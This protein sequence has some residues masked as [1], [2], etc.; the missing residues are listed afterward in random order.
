MTKKISY[1][2][3]T[4]RTISLENSSLKT[5]LALPKHD[6]EI[7][8]ICPKS[9]VNPDLEGVYKFHN[10]KIL[11]DKHMAGACKPS[12]DGYKISDGDYIAI[13]CDDVGFPINF[14][15]MLDF[16]ASEHVQKKRFK[17]SNSM[18]DGGPGLLTYGHDDLAD[19]VSRWW[20][21][22]R[23]IF[24]DSFYP[25]S[26]IP[27]PFYSR[28]TIEK[29]LGGILYHPKFKHHYC[30]HWSGF[31]VSKNETYK[32]FEW[33]CPTIH[34]INLKNISKMNS[35]HDKEDERTLIDLV[36]SF[37]VGETSYH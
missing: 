21:P 36:S 17:M 15:D 37:K 1:I 9:A 18:W 4:N 7:I 22:P 34:Y 32:P 30:D 24:P 3:P 8:I 14:L 29:E 20:P 27:L 35:F 6:K 31:Y 16:M 12:N 5:V 33:R 28:E 11:E 23:P 25:Y 19:G 2:L 13:M 26:V 10:I